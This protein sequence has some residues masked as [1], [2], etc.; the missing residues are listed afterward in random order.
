MRP[1]RPRALLLLVPLF[2][3]WA[4]LHGVYVVGLGVVGVYTLFTVA[5]SHT[6]G[7]RKGW[8]LAGLARVHPG[9]DGD[10]QPGQSASS[11]RCATSMLSDWGLAN[12]QEW[13]SPD[14]H[15][16]AHLALLGLIVAIG[17]N[18]GR[19]TPGWLVMLS[20]VGVAMAL[21]SLRNAPIAAIFALPTLA[22]G[23]EARLRARD[24][25]RPLQ[26]GGP[27][28]SRSAAGSS[29]SGRRSSS[30]SV[31]SPCWSPRS[32]ARDRPQHHRAIPV[33]LRRPSPRDEP[34]AR[35]LADYGWGGYVIYRMYAA[36]GRVFVDGRNDMY[37][38]RSSRTT[39]R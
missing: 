36:G 15:E 17:L 1:D 2:V 26:R 30:S 33:R 37:D 31:R 19:A 24:E 12:I 11:T 34:D 5:G 18:G 27:S 28:D 13:Q 7:E 3:L 29:R 39:T 35:V 10:A 14:F 22:L 23:L 38:Q 4:N 16:P 8:V 9:F 21:I 32:S 25:Q 20:W 6:N